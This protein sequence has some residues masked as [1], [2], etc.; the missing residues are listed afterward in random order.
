MR[1]LHFSTSAPRSTARSRPYNPRGKVTLRSTS[2]LW[3]FV[4]IV[5]VMTLVF[6]IVWFI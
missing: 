4:S 1:K 6:A 3:N 2:R 5:G